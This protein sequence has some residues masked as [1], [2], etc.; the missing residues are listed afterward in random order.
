VYWLAE[1]TKLKTDPF[2]HVDVLKSIADYVVKDGKEAMS[3]VGSC[4]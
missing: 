1:K 4:I 3:E 2:V